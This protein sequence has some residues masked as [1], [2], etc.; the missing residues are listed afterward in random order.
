MTPLRLREPHGRGKRKGVRARGFEGCFLSITGPLYS[1]TPSFYGY[2]YNI[3]SFNK[4][5]M[6]GQ[7]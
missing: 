6:A 5:R 1:G 2:L 7:W 3:K 4:S